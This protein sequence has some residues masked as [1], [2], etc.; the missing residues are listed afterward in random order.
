M[1]TSYLFIAIALCNVVGLFA[2]ARFVKTIMMALSALMALY[3][4]VRLL[5]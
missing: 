3:G 4:L 1:K 2:G 5:G